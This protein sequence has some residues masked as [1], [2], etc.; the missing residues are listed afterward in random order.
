MMSAF[1][2]R[3][4]IVEE[5]ADERREAIATDGSDPED[6]LE[7]TTGLDDA[8][9]KLISTGFTTANGI[10]TSKLIDIYNQL[11]KSK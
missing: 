11:P 9:V 1:N 10:E 8:V 4:F 7:D 2:L 5:N 6:D 3:E